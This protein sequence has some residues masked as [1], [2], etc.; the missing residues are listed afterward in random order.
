MDRV[1]VVSKPCTVRWGQRG[2][3]AKCV[4]YTSTRQPN[5]AACC[6]NVDV[7]EDN[8][9][10]GRCVHRTAHRRPAEPVA[11]PDVSDSAPAHNQDDAPRYAARA[12]SNSDSTV[13]TMTLDDLCAGLNEQQQ[14]A[15]RTLNGPLLVVAG[16]G[17]GKTRVL[18]HRVAALVAS[19]VDP[20]NILALTFTNK[21]AD[22]MRERVA[23][24]LDGDEAKAVWVS[25]FHSFCLRVLRRYSTAAGL[26]ANFTVLDQSDAERVIKQVC[27][28]LGLNADDA[29][30]F[31]SKV[32]FAKNRLDTP[33]DLAA[34]GGT[35]QSVARVYE[36]YATA[37][38]KL[39]AV[40]FDDILNIAR[41]LLATDDRVLR[42][43][44]NRFTYIMVDEWQDTNSCQYDIVRMLGSEHRQLC[45]VGDQQQ[46]IYGWRGST[47]EV[48]DA[49]ARDFPEQTTVI[50]G[51][52]YRSTPEIVAVAQSVI[53]ASPTKFAATLTTDNASGAV[54]RCVQTEDGQS[55]ATFVTNE[56]AATTGTRAILMRTNAQTRLFEAELTRC[57]IPY[58]LV[59]TVRF[60]DRAEVKDVL[61]YLRI[62]V[63]PR[64]TVA[65]ARA[66]GCPKRGLGDVGLAAFTAAADT[67][68][69]PP[70]DALSN[71]DILADC[72]ARTRGPLAA[73]G[74]VIDGAKTAGR[75]GVGAAIRHI[76]DAGVRA[77]HAGDR[78]RLENLDEL[79]AAAETF[80]T[81]GSSTLIGIDINTLEGNDRIT[82]F[83]ESVTLTG[84]S[85]GT[86]RETVSLITAHASK[87]REFDHVWVV[88]V[89][90]GLYPHTLS[91]GPAGVDE[92]RRLFFVAVSR[93][94]IGL[95]LTYRQRR[96]MHGQ[97]QD[98]DPS[99]FL[100]HLPASV[101][102][103][104]Q[105]ASNPA[106]TFT[107]NA[108][109]GRYSSRHS[110]R[111]ETGS[112][113]TPV[114]G[115]ARHT[116]TPPAG[117]RLADESKTV[118]VTVTHPVFG[119]G[120]ITA[121]GDG[122]VTVDFAGKKRTLDL[123]YAP[124]TAHTA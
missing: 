62:A 11:I 35:W 93:A 77:H 31:A 48:L 117:P 99:P 123:R 23:G 122:D 75:E 18:T 59:G 25:T 105:R 3:F 82:A 119:V 81:E 60:Y 87:G 110:N 13:G 38:R 1:S 83:L 51:Q 66:A 112:V 74:A 79:V 106:R 98:A 73:L 9:T 36:N 12:I 124:L 61:A 80:D 121:I 69:T 15:V 68:G 40:D 16:P 39:G 37:L 58:Q 113:R 41:D 44:R 100:N 20:H 47:P 70:G 72:P 111:N 76:L 45:V 50:L 85:D 63:N 43:L 34:R 118:G 108:P 14:Q 10:H 92:E 30:S 114:S 109:G 56:I 120:T 22:E 28:E 52:N 8:D 104:K 6:S 116:I 84:S 67:H 101:R 88:G 107:A 49:F 97:W 42:S 96:F 89:E 5:T 95:C 115:L 102:H 103:I 21:A 57:R 94:R 24:L 55:E 32:S 26:P 64:D 91:E 65:L 90:D 7:L 86:E 78:E 33:S 2:V 19:G 4:S 53:D 71:G 27:V 29:R 54:V 46:A 17:S